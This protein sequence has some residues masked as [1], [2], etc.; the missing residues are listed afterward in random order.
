MDAKPLREVGGQD[1]VIDCMGQG[2]AARG[3]IRRHEGIRGMLG[4]NSMMHYTRQRV[5]A[6]GLPF[7]GAA[8]VS[9]GLQA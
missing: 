2:F 8:A 3:T 4:G 5:L 7:G 1:R 6:A 9:A